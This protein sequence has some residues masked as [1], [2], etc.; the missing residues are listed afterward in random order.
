VKGLDERHVASAATPG[1][2]EKLFASRYREKGISADEILDHS[3]AIC[4][5]LDG[6]SSPATT[7]VQ[8]HAF[9]NR[10]VGRCALFDVNQMP[11]GAQWANFGNHRSAR[12]ALAL[13]FDGYGAESFGTLASGVPKQIWIALK[14]ARDAVDKRFVTEGVRRSLVIS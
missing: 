11:R 13:P 1:D 6:C 2:L 10:C 12:L 8:S 14:C 7:A 9:A 5:A 3:H 4:T